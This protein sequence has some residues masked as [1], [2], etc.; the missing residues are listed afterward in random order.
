MLTAVGADA[1]G[2][3]QATAMSSCR[4]RPKSPGGL[5]AA[6]GFNEGSS[7]QVTDASGQGNT[8]TISSATWAPAGRFGA[9][10][11]FNGT[12]S[13]VTVADAASV[14]LTTGMTIEAWVNPA[15]STGWRSV[16]LKET[17][18][19]LAYA[20]YAANNASLPAGYIHTST[21]VGLNGTTATPLNSWTHLAFTYDGAAM[22]MFVNGAQVSTRAVTGSVSVASGALRIGGNSVW[23]EYFRG[24]IDEVR[25]YNRPLNAGEI[26][27]DMSTPIP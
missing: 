6:Y 15:S 26:Q 18:G 21:D 22:R 12:S 1:A 4:T 8:G 13:W 27:A 10:L 9:A 25:I 24:L 11:S 19:G 17:G 14:R 3:S 23:G 20:L 5:V 2:N 7:V 16:V